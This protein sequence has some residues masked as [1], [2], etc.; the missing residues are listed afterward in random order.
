MN[1]APPPSEKFNLG[2]AL[3]SLAALADR[4]RQSEPQDLPEERKL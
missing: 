3:R 4:L 2:D 1:A